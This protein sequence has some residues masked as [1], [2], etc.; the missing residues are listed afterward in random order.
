MKNRSV[1][2]LRGLAVACLLAVCPGPAAAYIKVE[3]LTLGNLCRQSA[4]IYVLRVEKV[5]AE[6]GVILFKPVAQLKGEPDGTAAR[7]VIGPK[8]KGA[9]IILDWATE[10]KTAVMFCNVEGGYGRGH[11]C[12]DGYWYWLTYE[13]GSWSAGAGEPAWLTQYCGTADKL[14][15]ALVKILRGEEVVVPCMVTDNKEDLEQ[16]RARVQQLRASLK[17][18]V[19]DPKRNVVGDK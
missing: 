13:G 5:S 16:R 3:P 17:I 11:A 4:H 10:G 2:F 1:L 8:V 7:H 15:D 12:I 18:V 19:S 14:R 6:R 9:K